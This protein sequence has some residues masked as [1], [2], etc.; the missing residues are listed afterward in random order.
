M[1]KSRVFYSV[2]MQGQ[3]SLLQLEDKS[4]NMDA[5]KIESLVNQIHYQYAQSPIAEQIEG[6]AKLRETVVNLMDEMQV[7]IVDLDEEQK[8][9][10]EL[11]KRD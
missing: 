4:R 10:V 2:L 3:L 5:L 7:M 11:Q 1:I 8:R 6:V 9:L